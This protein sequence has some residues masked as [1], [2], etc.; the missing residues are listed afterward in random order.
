MNPSIFFLGK[1]IHLNEYFQIGEGG[2]NPQKLVT[3]IF[4]Y[5]AYVC[6][7]SSENLV[8]CVIH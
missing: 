5:F 7:K 3:S 8:G 2:Q 4:Q 1:S 6:L